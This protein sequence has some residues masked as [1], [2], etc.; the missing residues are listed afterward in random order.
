MKKII[1][2]FAAAALAFGVIGC[3]NDDLNDGEYLTRDSAD[4]GATGNYSTMQTA[5]NFTV[6]DSSGTVVT[7][8]SVKQYLD[9]TLTLSAENIEA[10]VADEKVA[11]ASVSGT[12]LKITGVSEGTTVVSL[13]MPIVSSEQLEAI[14]EEVEAELAEMVKNGYMTSAEAEEY[15]EET[16]ASY[17]TSVGSVTVTVEAA[18]IYQAAW[19]DTTADLSATLSGSTGY[20]TAITASGITPTANTDVFDASTATVAYDDLNKLN[21]Y[22]V[23]REI[24]SSN[25]TIAANTE[26]IN[27]TFSATANKDLTL[28]KLS[29]NASNNTSGNTAIQVYYSTD[30]ETYTAI[31]DLTKASS[32]KTFAISQSLSSIGK[33]ES[34]K[35]IYF[36]ITHTATKNITLK[37]TADYGFKVLLGQVHLTFLDNSAE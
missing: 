4:E 1:G 30:G 5:K 17:Y 19:F 21:G 6:K 13:A 28:D 35:T 12:S 34:G 14:Q 20:D 8:V 29:F 3:T 11:T 32:S 27:Y 37:S 7:S 26:F 18:T 22:V 31:G 25:Q 10:D 2:L 23:T 36:K 9:A 33:I 15:V 16:I 24:P